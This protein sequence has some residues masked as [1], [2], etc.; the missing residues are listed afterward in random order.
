MITCIIIINN[1]IIWPFHH[2]RHRVVRGAS[3]SSET[4]QYPGCWWGEYQYWVEQS[5]ELVCPLYMGSFLIP[6]FQIK[7]PIGPITVYQSV[8]Q[9]VRSSWPAIVPKLHFWLKQQE[10]ASQPVNLSM[11]DRLVRY[12]SFNYLHISQSKI[13]HVEKYHVLPV[14]SIIDCK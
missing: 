8:S 11:S 2:P 9:S 1:I 7:N 12:W 13:S 3:L 5:M 6:S 14:Q 4:L 10:L